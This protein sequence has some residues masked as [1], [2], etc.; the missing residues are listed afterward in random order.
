MTMTPDTP[1]QTP[2]GVGKL[3]SESLTILYRNIPAVMVLGF[4]PI[5]AQLLISGLLLGWSFTFEGEGDPFASGAALFVIVLLV[6]LGVYGLTTSLLVQMAYDAK[7]GRPIHP[8]RYVSPAIRA[9]IPVFILATV[10]GILTGIG[11]VFLV[12]PGLWI[13][14]VFAVTAPAIVIERA[15]FGGMG[16]SAQLTKEYRWP[17]LGF[18]VVIFICSFLIGIV[19]QF[20][21][22]FLIAAFGTGTLGI[23]LSVIINAALFAV[24]YGLS[25]IGVSLV[26]ARLREIKEGISVDRLA[27]VFE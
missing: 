24:T 4:L 23:G 9:A 26:Y 18:V 21:F 25:G 6:Q 3:I 8:K 17:V 2:L 27:D 14:A 7:L 10:T 22:G 11:I 13:Y 15:G 12:I 1:A 16:R 20:I 19:T 5:L